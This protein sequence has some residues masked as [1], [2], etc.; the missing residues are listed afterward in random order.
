MWVWYQDG[1]DRA[2][3]GRGPRLQPSHRQTKHQ[4]LSTGAPAMINYIDI[5][6]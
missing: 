5:P 2:A 3:G 4:D 6:L 1:E